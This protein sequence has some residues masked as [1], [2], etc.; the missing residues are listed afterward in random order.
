ME[1]LEAYTAIGA[2]VEFMEDRKGKLKPGFLADIVILS[3]DIERVAPDQIM[4]TVRPA[5]TIC[6]GRIT[7]KAA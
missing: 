6:D 2:W 1:S 5:V 3:H 4:D 7:H